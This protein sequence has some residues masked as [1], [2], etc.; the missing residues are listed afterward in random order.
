MAYG[1]WL[2]WGP[3]AHQKTRKPLANPWNR[4]DTRKTEQSPATETRLNAKVATRRTIETVLSQQ[5]THSELPLD[6]KSSAQACK[7]ASCKAFQRPL[8]RHFLFKASCATH[9]V[10]ACIEY[11][12]RRLTLIPDSVPARRDGVN[13]RIMKILHCTA[14]SMQNRHTLPFECLLVSTTPSSRSLRVSRI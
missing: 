10:L 12:L 4:P 9:I 2:Q 8:C 13:I 1:L 11:R 3:R 14:C 6:P 5:E 7:A